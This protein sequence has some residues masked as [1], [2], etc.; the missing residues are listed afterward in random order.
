MC[1]T[2]ANLQTSFKSSQNGWA[3]SGHVWSAC[4]VASEVK[5]RVYGLQCSWCENVPMTHTFTCTLDIVHFHFITSETLGTCPKHSQR[6]VDYFSINS[7]AI[8][9][10]LQEHLQSV[11]RIGLNGCRMQRLRAQRGKLQGL[12]CELT[13]SSERSRRGRAIK[14]TDKGDTQND[15]VAYWHKGSAGFLAV[16]KWSWQFK[17]SLEFSLY[18]RQ[19]R[20][21][22]CMPVIPAVGSGGC[23]SGST[24]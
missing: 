1:N 2:L 14:R 10:L 18:L 3:F 15:R 12:Q 20:A 11:V 13:F 21:E 17:W 16:F 19:K 9:T 24:T 23:S 5:N 8:P 7:T 4:S 6:M 22:W